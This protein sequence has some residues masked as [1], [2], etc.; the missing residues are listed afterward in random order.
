MTNPSQES[1]EKILA[2]TS[3]EEIK[4]LADNIKDFPIEKW[5]NHPDYTQ[6]IYAA[7]LH[8]FL[9]SDQSKDL[10]NRLAKLGDR[11]LVFADPT[12]GYLGIGLDAEEAK[13]ADRESWGRN[14]HGKSFERLRE[15]I[16]NPYSPKLF[17]RPYDT[18]W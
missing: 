15:K 18:M 13:T 2:A 4:A 7:N 3:E 14:E 10:L 5:V 17:S 12:D 1:Y 9:H 8:K 6:H 16:R 11:E